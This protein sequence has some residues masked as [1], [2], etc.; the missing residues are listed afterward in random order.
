MNENI[1][2]APTAIPIPEPAIEHEAVACPHC[3]KKLD[4]DVIATF[5]TRSRVKF[6][7]SPAPGELFTAGTVGGLIDAA[8]TLLKSVGRDTGVPTEVLVE[9]CVMAEDGRLDV[10][11]LIARFE[12]AEDRARRF[13]AK[14]DKKQVPE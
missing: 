6:S 10:D 1:E 3:G 13:A 7:M 12:E 2:Q 4:F 14:R 8:A 9:K 5:Q 11:F